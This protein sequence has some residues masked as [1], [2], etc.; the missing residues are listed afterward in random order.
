MCTY[1]RCFGTKYSPLKGMTQTEVALADKGLL[2]IVK[3]KSKI[4]I[5]KWQTKKFNKKMKKFEKLT[6]QQ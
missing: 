6:K 3:I 2:K 4:K 1:L 5:K